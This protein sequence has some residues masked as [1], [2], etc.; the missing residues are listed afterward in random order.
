E[1]GVLGPE[2]ARKWIRLM[3]DHSRGIPLELHFHNKTA[4]ANLNHIIGVEEGVHI[5]HSAI[6]TLANGVSMPSTE[7][8]V[9]NMRRLGHEGAVDESRI[10]E[11]AAHFGAL[12]DDEGF[13]RGA[14]VE[15]QV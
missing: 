5:V 13:A 14:P 9:D 10:A 2:R 7:V 15:Y 3:Q 11:V 8:T 4:M 6:S 1:A 12:A